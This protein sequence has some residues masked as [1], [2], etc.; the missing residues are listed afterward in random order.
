[1]R[2]ITQKTNLDGGS[3]D[4]DLKTENRL[5]RV[6]QVRGQNQ[7]GKGVGR[8]GQGREREGEEG[9]GRDGREG[10]RRARKHSC[11]IQ[12][13]CLIFEPEFFFRQCG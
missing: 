12:I 13:K 6:S 7:G 11:E 8:R 3:G 4:I 9:E 5:G 2:G 1:M 10:K